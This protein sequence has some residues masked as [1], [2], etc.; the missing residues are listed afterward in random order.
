[1]STKTNVV[2]EPVKDIRITDSYI[3]RIVAE[4]Q[5]R[6]GDKTA[7]KTAAQMILER[8]AQLEQRRTAPQSAQVA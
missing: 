1:M 4:E 6:R 2:E 3:T 7:T 5:T 8:Y